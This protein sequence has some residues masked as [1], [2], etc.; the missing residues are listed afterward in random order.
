MLIDLSM[1]SPF[2]LVTNGVYNWN[3]LIDEFRITKGQAVYETN[4]IIPQSQFPN[5]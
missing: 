1:Y 2:E 3:G 4:F 5:S